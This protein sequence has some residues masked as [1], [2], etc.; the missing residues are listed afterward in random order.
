MLEGNNFYYGI[1]KKWELAYTLCASSAA[2]QTFLLRVQHPSER[3]LF[4]RKFRK[5]FL[6]N[7]NPPVPMIIKP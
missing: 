2:S 6:L 5:N 1:A 7:K 4:N 3:F